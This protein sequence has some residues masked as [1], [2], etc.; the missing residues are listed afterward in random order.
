MAKEHK[1]FK[2]RVLTLG[3]QAARMTALHPQFQTA[4]GPSAIT[5]TGPIRPSELSDE[6][7]VCITHNQ[8]SRSKPEVRV[9]NPKLQDRSDGARVPH[10][11]PGRRPCLY[12]PRFGE[13]GPDKFIAQTIVPWTALWLYYYE[14][15][16]ATGSWLGGGHSNPKQEDE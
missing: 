6:Y 13:W 15:W 9:L 8:N 7:L 5:W 14:V 3:Q 16:H 12:Y 1:Y 11:Y 4:W 10:V 2:A